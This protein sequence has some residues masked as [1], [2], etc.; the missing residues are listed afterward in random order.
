MKPP[1]SAPGCG[2]R[3]EAARGLCW[4]HYSEAVR[5]DPLPTPTERFW[6]RV[7]RRGDDECWEWT[8]A[9]KDTGY[10]RLQIDGLRVRAH[11]FAWE[12]ANGPIPAGLSVCHRCDNPPCCNPAHLFLGTPADNSRDAATKGRMPHGE[13]HYR[14][15]MTSAQV[16]EIRRLYV[17]GMSLGEIAR[18]VGVPLGSVGSVTGGG[19]RAV[20]FDPEEN[21][22]EPVKCLTCGVEQDP[23]APVCIHMAGRKGGLKT[24]LTHG[25]EHFRE[26]GRRGGERIALRG[27]E[28][29]QEIGRKGGEANLAKH[30]AVFM[31]EIGKKGG[32]TIKAERGT[33]FYEEIGRKGGAKERAAFAA[34][35][36]Q[37]GEEDAA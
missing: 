2:E 5:R 26:A 27:R 37:Q 33:P 16:V 6:A 24:A 10:G 31:S 30:G 4:S 14:A 34:L 20:P 21:M 23:D 3:A 11:R 35:R 36:Q 19:W 7:A 12:L 1:C 17:R 15:A 22:G 32:E 29:Y 13:R 8:G 28:Y 9:R 18:T 25:P